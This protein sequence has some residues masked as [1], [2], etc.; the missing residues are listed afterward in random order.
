MTQLSFIQP[1]IWTISD[2]T[3]YLRDL[4]E[5]DENLQDLWA[6][7]EVSNLSRPRS[8]HL[9]FTLKDSQSALRCVMWRPMVMRLPYLPQDGDAVQVH[10]SISIYETAGQYQLFADIIRPVGEGVLYQE[11]IRLKAKLEAEGLFD[12]ERKRPIPL[13]PK[14]I[15]L[16]TSPTGAALRDI[17]NTIQRRYTLAE[18]ILAPTQV[19]GEGAPKTITAAIEALNEI[20]DL[21]VILIARGGGSLEDLWAFNDEGVARAIASSNTPII[22]GIGH[23]TDFTIADFVS[24]LRASTPTAAAELAAP[25]RQDL[26]TVLLESADS[27]TRVILTG[28]MD[29]RLEVDRLQHKL[30]LLSPGVRL[31]SDRQRL[32]EILHR[33]EKSTLHHL[34]LKKAQLHGAIQHLESLNPLSALQRGYSAVTLHDGTIIHS[35]HQVQPGDRI[36]VRVVDGAMTALVE[37]ITGI[38]E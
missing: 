13:L 17:L 27:M 11:F 24:D 37:E 18:V 7:G 23:E 36:N 32:D 35:I 21:D 9:Y 22:T 19:Q 8:G 16:V 33:A 4:L 15:G 14:K 29:K 12:Q 28:I 38:N 34:E 31:R 10:G 25:N 26:K 30:V 5:G 1:Q 20:A 2:L 3:R 6:S